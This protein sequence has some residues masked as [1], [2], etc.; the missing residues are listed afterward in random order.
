[1]PGR[2]V[3]RNSLRGGARK[4]FFLQISRNSFD[5]DL[6]LEINILRVILG[7]IFATVTST[8]TEDDILRFLEENLIRRNVRLKASLR[9]P[10]MPGSQTLGL[11][12]TMGK[13]FCGVTEKYK[14]FNLSHML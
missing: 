8:I 11:V 12:T 2:G 7:D 3:R 10:L 14:W 4:C 9:T 1:M 13:L 5:D 6:F